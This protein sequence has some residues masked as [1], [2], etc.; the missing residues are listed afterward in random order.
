MDKIT[1]NYLTL[2]PAYGR[3]YKNRV[4]VEADFRA[5]KD[6]EMASLFNG[7]GLYCSIQDFASGVKVNIRYAKQRNVVIV[8]V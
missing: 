3:D 5:S 6:F 2:V 4:Q 8:K 7:G 1:Q